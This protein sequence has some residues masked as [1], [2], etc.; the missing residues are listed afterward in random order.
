[1]NNLDREARLHELLDSQQR[2]NAALESL[3]RAT[4]ALASSLETDMV[5]QA[6]VREAATMAVAPIVRSRASA[7]LGPAGALFLI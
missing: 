4:E 3:V 1:M 7:H 5:L 6:V 2:A